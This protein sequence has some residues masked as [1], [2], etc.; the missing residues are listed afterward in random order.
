M[1]IRLLPTQIPSFWEAIKY[2]TVQAGEV[3]EKDRQAC[4]NELLHALLNEKAQCFVRL[5]DE[6]RLLAIL[7][8][9]L[10]IDKVTGDKNLFAQAMY[11]WKH[12][13]EELWQD[14][15]KFVGD[16]AIHEQCKYITFESNNERLWKL[17]KFFGFRES[18]RKFVLSL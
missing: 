1:H 6:R 9:R 15:M 13:S 5:N 11:S 12:A 3:N 8:T 16:F 7:I 4:L 18:L 17:A 10:Q 14:V 2:A